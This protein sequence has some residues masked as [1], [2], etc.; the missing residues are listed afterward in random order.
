LE[1][2]NWK[3]SDYSIV[4]I[5]FEN[6][7]PVMDQLLAHGQ[8]TA[9]CC[10]NDR[11]AYELLRACAERGVRVPEEMAITGFDGFR[12]L[13]IPARQ[14]VSIHCPWGRVAATALDLLM[15][16]VQSDGSASPGAGDGHAETVLPVEFVAGDTA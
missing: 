10:W 9:V 15:E 11:T 13:R 8:G 12:D 7:L 16:M 5:D 1:R 2:R 6:V 3:E 14:V 4:T